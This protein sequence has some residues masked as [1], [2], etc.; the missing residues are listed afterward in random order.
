M[1]A[2]AIARKVT[3]LVPDAR[4]VEARDVGGSVWA[5]TCQHNGR[6]KS[7]QSTVGGIYPPAGYGMWGE[8]PKADAYL[9]TEI[10]KELLK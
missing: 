1:N 8:L 10:A 9:A 3:E 6:T 4:N 5:L 2:D 7:V